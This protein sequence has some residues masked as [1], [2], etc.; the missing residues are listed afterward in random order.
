MRRLSQVPGDSLESSVTT[1]A[2]AAVQIVADTDGF[3]ADLRRQ[4][5]QAG[6]GADRAAQS[7]GRRLGQSLSSGLNTA[8]SKVSQSLG[9]A[10]SQVG[11][12]AQGAFTKVGQAAQTAFGPALGQINQFRSGFVSVDD[13]ASIF[14]TRMG[15]LGVRTREFLDPALHQIGRF[16][17]GFVSSGAAASAFS[18]RMGTLGGVA[19]TAVDGIASGFSRIGAS[20]STAMSSAVSGLSNM[21]SRIRE[22]V[23]NSNLLETG[24][25]KVGSVAAGLAAA[26]GIANLGAEIGSVASSAQTTEASL[27]ALYEASGAGAAEVNEVME[28]MSTR[29]RGL[30]MS[31]MN[32]GA[33]TLAY[34]GLQGTEAVDVLERL[35]NATTAAGTGATGMTRALD[36]MTK[37]VNAGKFQMG[38]LSQISN[39][40]IPIYDALADVLG[41]DVPEAQAMASAG[42]ID[43]EH[44]L[45][46]MS[47]EAGTWFP[48]LMEGAEGVSAT[49][50][51][52]WDT[53]RNSFVNGLAYELVP[54]LDR[55]SPIMGRVADVVTAGFDRLPQ[56]VSSAMAG[57]RD[58][59]ALDTLTG[60]LHGMRDIMGALAPV[61]SGF[62]SGFGA[63][64]RG[65][66]D[67]LGYL[68]PLAS[69]LGIVQGFLEDNASSL[70]ALGVALGGVVATLSAFRAASVA[71]SV[72]Q[73][74][75]SATTRSIDALLGITR[76]WGAVTKVASASNLTFAASFRAIGV[77]IRAIPVIGWIIGLIGLLIGGITLLWKRSETFRRIVTNAWEKVQD[78]IGV[79]VDHIMGFVDR[80]RQGWDDLMDSASNSTFWS[81]AWE[82]LVS[83]A[84]TAGTAISTVIDQIKD[85]FG[86]VGDLFRGE[87]DFE[88]FISDSIDRFRGLGQAI[89]EHIIGTLQRLPG[90]AADAIGSFTSSIVT[91]LTNLPGQISSLLAKVDL[92]DWISD[93]S[94]QAVD[95]LSGI[96]TTVVD[97]I[98]S[99]P[100]RIS[101][102]IDAAAIWEWL[103]DAGSRITEFMADYGPQILRGLAVALGVAVLGVPALVLGLAAA[104]LATLAVVAWELLKWAASAFGD[105]MVAAGHAIRDGLVNLGQWFAELPSR[106]GQYLVE[107]GNTIIDFFTGLPGRVSDLVG[108]EDGLLQWMKDLP[109][110]AVAYLAD[111]GKTISQNLI[112]R[113]QAIPGRIRSA[114]GAE[115][116]LLQ[117]MKDLPGQAQEYLSELATTIADYLTS[118]PGKAREAITGTGGILDWLRDAPSQAVTYLQDLA[119]NIVDYLRGIP[120]RIRNLMSG[121]SGFMDWLRNAPSQAVEYLSGLGTTIVEYIQSL[122]GRISDAVDP[123]A[124]WEWLQNAGSR[125]TEFMSDYGPQILHGIAIAIGVVVMG[126][127]ALLLGLLAAIVYV[128]GIIAWE[129]SLWA[130]EA[131]TDM[132]T[133]AG[134]AVMSG[135]DSIVLWFQELPGRIFESL[136]T[137]GIDLYEWG[138]SALGS[139]REAF[140]SGLETLTGAWSSTWTS[141]R[142]T[143]SSTWSSIVSWA[144]T[145]AENLRDNVMGPI[146]TL[147]DRMIG[148]FQSARRGIGNVWQQLKHTVGKPIAWVVNIGYNEWIRGVWGK[149]VD[150]FDGPSLPSYTV[151]FAKGGIFP[152][153]GG[154]VFSGY[155]PGR[156]VHAMPMAA[157]SG[158]ESVLRP[159]VTKA[160]GAGTTHMLNKL[161]RSGGVAAVRKALA[162][163]FAGHNPFT[164]MSV[165]RTNPATAGAGAG[166]AQRFSSGGILGQVTG[167]LSGVASWL[168]SKKDDFSEA[169]MD[170]LDDPGGI[171]RR[172]LAQVVD[173]SQMPGWGSDWTSVL[174]KIPKKIIDMLVEQ[175]KSLFSIDAEGD[176]LNLGGSVGGRLG[177]ALAFAKSQV[178]K[179]YIWGGV[180]PRGYD[181][182]I[183][184]GVRVYGPRGAKRIEDIQ[185]GEQ[186]YSYVD[187]KL[188]PH[189]VNAV[190]QSDYQEVFEVRTRN[191]KVTAS[192]N[193][194]FMRLVSKPDEKATSMDT[195]DWN[196]PVNMPRGSRGHMKCTVS[197]CDTLAWSKGLCN[198]HLSRWR[199]H[200]DPRVRQR[201][202]SVYE[203]EWAR[204]DELG[205]GDLL[206][207][208]RETPFECEEK[209]L[210]E[211]GFP[212]T[213]DFAWLVG[214]CVGDGTVTD[215]GLRLALY[216]KER[217][218]ATQII[219][220]YFGGNPTH[221]QSFGIAISNKGLQRVLDSMGMR[222]KGLDKRVPDAVWGWPQTHRRAF[223]DGYCDAD[224]SRPNNPKRNE[225]RTYHSASEELIEDVRALHIALGDPVSNISVTKRTKPI[226]I[227]G[228]EVK[229]ALPQYSFSVW[230]G[231]GRGEAA[232]RRSPGVAQWLDDGDFTLTKVLEI[233]PQGKQETWDMEV[234]QAH[235]FIA[236][237]VVV[238][239]SGFMSAIHNV[240][241]GKSPYSRR[242]TTHGFT[243]TMAHGF[244]R[245]MPSP[246]TLGNTH[247]SVGHMAGTL[248]KTNV[249]SRGSAGVVV[250]SRARGTTNPLFTS[251]WGLITSGASRGGRMGGEGILYDSGG[252]LWPGTHLVS[253]KTGR[254][255]SIRSYAQEERV[256]HLVRAVEKQTAQVARS[257]LVPA[258]RIKDLERVLGID[259]RDRDRDRDQPRVYA[260]ITVNTQAS[261]PAQVAHKVVDR[262]VTRAGV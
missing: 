89:A 87:A 248:L 45:E 133:T 9:P 115:D 130:W 19:R 57:M 245:N 116:G 185:A 125:I 2:T 212:V 145:Q 10:F 238:H 224:G 127:P 128:L 124:I 255:E 190:W 168:N 132:M 194:P 25:G 256:S 119:G 252:T 219:K 257:P 84:Q 52:S 232:L 158:G 93:A 234:D 204:L 38:E 250:G 211:G 94:S 197:T 6:A 63:V 76:L 214:A 165:P 98:K 166:F 187:G 48:A 254:P 205:R 55:L 35:D 220:E 110:Q 192:A 249:E 3:E 102:A 159:E 30:D 251:R 157:F 231:T 113:V 180:G 109:G 241:M 74:T 71:L 56:V 22:A 188:V 67:L 154:G 90:M 229:N 122:P 42:A 129:L 215:R 244:R 112:E 177:A 28:E 139:L 17:D 7:T 146:N 59:G 184:P 242:Y 174:S 173:Y 79:A 201:T 175:A 183:I 43:L 163:L 39:A 91:A 114:L 64:V 210:L 31:V 54:L 225:D 135:I 253:N 82:N 11:K 152:G 243:G 8:V 70:R 15:V 142:T 196:G 20:A 16:R 46:A 33:T 150:K 141:L 101:E 12:T 117:W 261:D 123:A 58:S 99:I 61:M 176:W 121:D 85:T 179:P 167:S 44:V 155:T 160:W 138:E 186:V 86:F 161:A 18:G 78:V 206:V 106:A 235:N 218:R 246:F 111:L 88:E 80:L 221:G 105:M 148:A 75:I 171:L 259:G 258:D 40:G 69:E 228:K 77:A 151:E 95:Y 104:I 65:A 136:I 226:V 118:I 1:L 182:C 222:R 198:S 51:G 156:D 47:G 207:Q 162:M 53:I 230:R 29:F 213:E 100:D 237:G 24:I 216:G 41:V 4:L 233:T 144:T 260:P 193:H 178:G 14:N 126:I 60:A 96:G 181:C 5:D 227:K 108:A 153:N 81:G 240:I 203:V 170:F 26:A 32:E 34:M 191:R 239:N 66:A 49:F 73:T 50:A 147:K 217:D 36:A 200:G 134:E 199:K 27:T 169:M 209:P 247:A 13:A 131:F 92:W 143:A 103:K 140:D 189:T 68:S 23:T 164:G 21:T 83:A 195:A 120:D 97:Y 72:A 149:L 202:G 172:L 62:A 223:L 236:D 37:G 262:L 107:L 208:P 137:F